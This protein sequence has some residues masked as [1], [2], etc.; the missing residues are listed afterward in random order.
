MRLHRR[1]RAD[2]DLRGGHHDD[3]HRHGLDPAGIHPL[4]DALVYIPNDPSDP[5]LQ[6]FPAGITCDVCGATAAGDPLVTTFTAP[7]GTF[8]LSNVPVGASVP[9]VVQLGRWRR[10]FTVNIA[11]LVRRQQRPRGHR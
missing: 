6:P 3:A 2:P 1:L 9:L 4:Y 7:D 10:Q 11:D 8:T 5:G